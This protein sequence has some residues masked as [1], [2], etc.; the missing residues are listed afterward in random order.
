MHVEQP[1]GIHERVVVERGHID[2]VL[3]ERASDRIHL[4]VDQH[5]VAGDRRL[6]LGGWLE[7]DH[8]RHAH[9]REQRAAHL[10]DR[11]RARNR[12]L[13]HP[14]TNVSTRTSQGLLDLFGVER[15]AGRRGGGP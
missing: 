11:F 3:L 8:R 4:F 10:G 7:I 14:A 12:D 9:G 13:E 2:A 15:G 1:R 6:A 5:E